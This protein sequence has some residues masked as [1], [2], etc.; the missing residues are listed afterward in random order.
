MKKNSR[1][2][3]FKECLA[4]SALLLGFQPTVFAE[5][6]V[7]ENVF[8]IGPRL[9]YSTPKDAD[10]GEWSGGAQARLHLSPGLGLESSIDY[11]SNDYGRF[12]TIKT[13]PV[14]ASLLAY[15]IPGAALSPFL[16]GGVGWYYTQ[17]DGPA[18]FNNTTSRFGLHAGAGLEIMLN[19]TLSLDGSYRYVWLESVTSADSNALDK[20]YRDKGSM[21]TIALNFLF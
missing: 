2:K 6:G 1:L 9:T 5:K 13:Y 16:L 3:R 4:M 19:K 14:Q 21:I 7:G 8:S 12:T 10:E 15:L 18:G 17:I 11:R 20:T